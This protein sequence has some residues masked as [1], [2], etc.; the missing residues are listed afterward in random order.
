MIGRLRGTLIEKQPPLIVLDVQGVGYEVEA[1]MNTILGL[2][3]LGEVASLYTHLVVREDAHLLY[4]FGD[5]IE[6]RLFRELIKISGVGPRMAIAILSGMDRSQLVRCL[7]DGDTKAL[8]RLPGVGKKTAE[9]LVIE[10]RDRLEKWPALTAD[11]SA[12]DDGLLAGAMGDS[13][14]VAPDNYAD[15]ESALI[16]LGYKPTEAA[17]MLSDLDNTASTEWLIKQALSQK[18]I[19]SERRSTRG[20][21]E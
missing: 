7:M 9:R 8:T 16:A 19:P 12:S 4:G 6:R 13:A 17:K 21:A 20:A 18:L 3:R 2:P 14:P 15:A 10:M 1:S 5:D 11:M